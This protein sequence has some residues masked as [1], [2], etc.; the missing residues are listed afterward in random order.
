[1]EGGHRS[2]DGEVI[3]DQQRG[4]PKK[5]TKP[6]ILFQLSALVPNPIGSVPNPLIGASPHT[7][8]HRPMLILLVTEW[9]E[10]SK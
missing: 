10:G 1:M 9:L 2:E 8:P 3:G 7:D 5:C 6:T 4:Y